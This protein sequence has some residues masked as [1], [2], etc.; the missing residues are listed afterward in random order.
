VKTKFFEPFYEGRSLTLVA[1]LAAVRGA[2]CYSVLSLFSLLL[3]IEA[4][5]VV[6]FLADFWGSLTLFPRQAVGFS[7]D[8]LSG[9]SL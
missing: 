8:S 9:D 5:G 2:I 4:D 1:Y 7:V 6:C 3:R